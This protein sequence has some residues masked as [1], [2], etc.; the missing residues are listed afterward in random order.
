MYDGSSCND[1]PMRTGGG[2][3]ASTTTI[4]TISERSSFKRW[5]VTVN[6]FR[7]GLNQVRISADLISHNPPPKLAAAAPFGTESPAKTCPAVGDRTVVLF[8]WTAVSV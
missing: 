1:C 6:V 8:S 5:V 2:A 4:I 3:T 7:P